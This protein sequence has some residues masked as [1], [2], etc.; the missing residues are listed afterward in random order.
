MSYFSSP[1]HSSPGFLPH[2]VHSPIS[3]FSIGLL[4]A[5]EPRNSPPLTNIILVAIIAKA[6]LT[7]N[8]ESKTV[9]KTIFL[10]LIPILL[11]RP[12]SSFGL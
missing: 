6:T 4:D 2:T 8:I 12:Q 1:L 7:I 5:Q 3:F 9:F 10:S 11:K